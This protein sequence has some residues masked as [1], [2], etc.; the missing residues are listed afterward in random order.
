[1]TTDIAVLRQEEG[2]LA[3]LV[4]HFPIIQNAAPKTQCFRYR[5]LFP[6]GRIQLGDS[7]LHRKPSGPSL[8]RS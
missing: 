1:M 5:L 2:L 7:G 8:R 4:S 6:R 3:E